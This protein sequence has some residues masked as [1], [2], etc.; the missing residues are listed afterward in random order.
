[1]DKNMLLVSVSLQL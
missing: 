1:V